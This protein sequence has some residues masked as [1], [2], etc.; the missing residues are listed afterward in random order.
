L[1]YIFITHDLT[2]ITYLCDRVIFL[3]AGKI[4]AESTVNDLAN[5]QDEYAQSLMHAVLDFTF[6]Q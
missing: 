3:K 4:T 6:P 1:T 5:V 2:T